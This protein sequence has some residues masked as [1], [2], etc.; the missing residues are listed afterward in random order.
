M[1]RGLGGQIRIP[2]PALW[3]LVSLAAYAGCTAELP[4]ASTPDE[5]P[6]PPDRPL[7]PAADDAQSRQPAS[8][9]ALEQTGCAIGQ[10]CSYDEQ[11]VERGK[12][13]CRA[14]GPGQPGDPCDGPSDCAAGLDCEVVEDHIC[15]PFCNEEHLCPEG[16]SCSLGWESPSGLWMPDR[17]LPL[18]ICDVLGNDC[19]ARET[20]R[21]AGSYESPLCTFDG[22]TPIGEP[23]VFAN[24]CVGGAT[25]VM[26]EASEVGHCRRICSLASPSCPGGTSC[27][28][29][30]EVAGVCL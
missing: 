23:C 24:D 16:W 22:E 9:D 8:C 11:D 6:E 20:C 13:S 5:A 12:P 21:W 15:L 17:C 30:T 19:A 18:D 2:L 1:S 3:V 4:T 26:E 7:D 14:A 27:A 10:A 29:I 25:C 28:P